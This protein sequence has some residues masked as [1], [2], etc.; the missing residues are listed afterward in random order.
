[1]LGFGRRRYTKTSLGAF[2]GEML[3]LGASGLFRRLFRRLF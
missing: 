3:L 1:M 2:Q